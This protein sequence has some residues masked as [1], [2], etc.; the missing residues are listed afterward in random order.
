M[1]QTRERIA[2][3]ESKRVNISAKVLAAPKE[4]EM[5]DLLKLLLSRSGV[6]LRVELLGYGTELAR[7]DPIVAA[8]EEEPPDLILLD[9]EFLSDEQFYRLRASPV[10]EETPILFLAYRPHDFVDKQAKRLGAKGYVRVPF[11][12]QELLTALQAV[13]RGETHYPPLPQKN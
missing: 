8:A 7:I 2:L 9:S 12:P 4:S 6:T 5:G 3:G 1:T 13:L 10:L 11:A